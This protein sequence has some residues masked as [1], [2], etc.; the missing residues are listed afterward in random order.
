LQLH[1]QSPAARQALLKLHAS[2]GQ[3]PATRNLI[4][5]WHLSHGPIATT[6]DNTRV[7]F[8]PVAEEVPGRNFYPADISR[9]ELDSYL[10]ENPDDADVRPGKTWR[11]IG[12][13]S[14]TTRRSMRYILV[15]ASGLNRLRPIAASYTRFRMPCHLRRNYA[16]PACTSTLLPIIY[17]RKPRTSQ[18]ICAIA[19][20][21]F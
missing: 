7:A 16:R 3:S 8:V 13:G 15:F 21:T 20:A 9:Q 11:Q 14:T 18:R 5:L 19:H 2:T 12:S 6:L 10:A 17:N 1:R 4:D